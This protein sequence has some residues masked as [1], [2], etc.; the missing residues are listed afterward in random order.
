M[1]EPMRVFLRRTELDA[2]LTRELQ[3]IAGCKGSTL[4]AGP[5]ITVIDFDDSNWTDYTVKPAP[6]SHE[7]LVRAVAGGVVSQTRELY[8]VVD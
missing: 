1:V 4:V 6:R 3:K 8:N 2:M 7:N 5:Q